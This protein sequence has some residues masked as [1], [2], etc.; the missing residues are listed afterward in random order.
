MSSNKPADPTDNRT[1]GGTDNT[2]TENKTNNDTNTNAPQTG[3]MGIFHVCGADY[4]SS[5]Y[6]NNAFIP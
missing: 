5:E 6:F 3:D 4:F 1:S 2:P